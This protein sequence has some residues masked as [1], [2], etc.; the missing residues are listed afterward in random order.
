MT[1]PEDSQ[2]C[3]RGHVWH[4]PKARQTPLEGSVTGPQP[5]ETCFCGHYQFRKLPQGALYANVYVDD[6]GA[7]V[8][9]PFWTTKAEA[10]T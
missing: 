7:V 3:E 10:K 6:G 8:A 2:C 9:G 1:V 5:D 4:L